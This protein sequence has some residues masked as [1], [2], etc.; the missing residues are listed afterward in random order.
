MG[1]G[2][3]KLTKRPIRT[4]HACLIQQISIQARRLVT[5]LKLGP[6][7]PQRGYMKDEILHCPSI[8]SEKELSI[9][10]PLNVV[11]H[12]CTDELNAPSHPCTEQRSPM[13]AASQLLSDTDHVSDATGPLVFFLMEGSTWA[14]CTAL[15]HSNAVKQSGLF[16]FET[17]AK[18]CFP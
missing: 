6:Y 17:T 8:K 10:I 9:I 16:V 4:T 13:S 3:F 14:G 12:A 15:A 7:Y 2:Q 18:P 5:H 1:L 11:S